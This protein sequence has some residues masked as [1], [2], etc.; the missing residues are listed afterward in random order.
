[1][2]GRDAFLDKV[3]EAAANCLALQLKYRL[4]QF[5]CSAHLASRPKKKT[6]TVEQFNDNRLG[7]FSNDLAITPLAEFAVTKMSPRHTEPVS[8]LMGIS[9]TCVIE[10]DPGTYSVV[11]IRALCDV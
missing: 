6:V 2:E 4:Y 11:T 1:M 7:S 5:T 3:S 9:E 8:R 10:R